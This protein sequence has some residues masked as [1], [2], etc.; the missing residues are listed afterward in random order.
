MDKGL[1]KYAGSCEY[2]AALLTKRGKNE[3]GVPSARVFI[4]VGEHVEIDIQ[5]CSSLITLQQNQI[6]YLS[7]FSIRLFCFCKMVCL[8]T[9]P[10]GEASG[11]FLYLQVHDGHLKNLLRQ[12]LAVLAARLPALVNVKIPAPTYGRG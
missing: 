3:Q 2:S 10:L 8:F 6:P 7:S 4:R 5:S 12:P 9:C 1:K 11:C